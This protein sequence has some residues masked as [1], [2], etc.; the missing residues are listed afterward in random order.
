MIVANRIVKEK[1][2]IKNIIIIGAGQAGAQAA[3]SARAAGFDGKIL[4]IG[5]EAVLPYQ[6]PPLSK[7]FLQGEFDEARLYLRPQE[8]YNGQKIE[9]MLTARVTS[10]DR[11][12]KTVE[13]SKGEILPYD[14]LLIATGAPPRHIAMLGCDLPG[15]HYLR[16]IGDGL[17]L[18]SMVADAKK[19][20]VIGAGYIG[21]EVAASARKA[22]LEVC[23]IEMADRVLARVASEPLS[24][25][26]E[27]LH[28]ENGIDLRLGES[29]SEILGD[30]HVNG[31][32]LAN[33]ERLECDAVVV[34]IGAVPAIGLAENAGLKID[35]GIATDEFGRTSDPNIFAAGDCASHLSL[36]Y[37]E[38]IRLESVPNAIEQA[39]SAG[40][41]MVGV[42]KVYDTLPWFWSDQ[43]ESK[44]Q[45][46]GLP[47][48]ADETVL[49]ADDKSLSVW[50]LS[51]GRLVSVDAVNDP[52]A[53]VVGK[54]LIAAKATPPTKKLADRNFD[55]K[56]LIG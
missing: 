14:V 26:Y 12:N 4:L 39:K 47:I 43:F 27:K 28:R 15:V 34:G 20:C 3:M 49:R 45:T 13:T 1:N 35:N 17:A 48:G 23:I 53:F 51:N 38:R 44:L 31:V 55:L 52:V 22:G 10:I 33:G 29:V 16:S 2:L 41:T 25:F 21:L 11:A 42:S 6:R 7:A 24:A 8:F 9:L 37:G 40:A 56:S 50:T 30:G 54:K 19:I 18:R 32:Q 36:L 5:D 46:A